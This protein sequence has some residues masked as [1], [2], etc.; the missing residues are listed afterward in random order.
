[1]LWIDTRWR[2]SHGIARFATNVICRLESEY[3]SFAPAV[4]PASP[5]DWLL[6]AR[7]A[8]RPGD[9]LFTPGFNVGLSRARQLA[10]VHDL[11]HL[12]DPGERSGLKRV[13]FSRVLKPC[14]RRNGM[15]LTVTRASAERL[16]DWLSDD[17]IDVRV[18]GNGIDTSFLG[19]VDP[20]HRRHR[21]FLF[22]GNAR[23]HKNLDVVLAALRL[24]P[25][26][27]LDLVTGDAEQVRRSATQF[28]VS[29]QIRV[30]HRVSDARLREL[31]RSASGLLMPS[32]IEGFGLP[33]VEATALGT[34]VAIWGGCSAL[35]EVVD[36]ARTI[37]V[38]SADDPEEWAAATDRLEELGPGAPDP[39]W[40]DSMSWN[41]VAERVE[42]A[43]KAMESE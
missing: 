18:V 4:S 30:Q 27:H 25:D 9:L 19:E 21:R 35:A 31:Y 41:A 22:I 16:R 32:R 13:Y 6:P 37:T 40:L 34:P 39:V 23:P 42:L 29:T 11:I 43:V 38:R 3:R 17:T 36:P 14:I 7:M 33:A 24:R 2:G 15:V 26:I 1:M 28:G 12:D 10:T 20:S 8:L 5:V